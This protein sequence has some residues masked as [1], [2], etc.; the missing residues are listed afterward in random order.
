MAEAFYVATGKNPLNVVGTTEMIN[1]EKQ[2]IFDVYEDIAQTA[3]NQHKHKNA[4]KSEIGTW[5]HT[6]AKNAMIQYVRSMGIAQ[7]Q[8]N[9]NMFIPSN[10]INMMPY[11]DGIGVEQNF[12]GGGLFPK[13]WEQDRI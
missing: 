13:V 12:S 2:K 9:G 5:T 8:K 3:Y 7:P 10:N 11:I 6:D 1:R 4:R